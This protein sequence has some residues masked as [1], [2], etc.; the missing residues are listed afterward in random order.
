MRPVD[1]RSLGLE[2]ARSR[3]VALY[4]ETHR[5]TGRL[6]GAL[7]VRYREFA[8]ISSPPA[9]HHSHFTRDPNVRF[10]GIGIYRSDKGWHRSNLGRGAAS[11]WSGPGQVTNK[12]RRVEHALPIVRDEFDRLFLGRVA[13]QH[14]PPP[15]HRLTQHTMPLPHGHPK[16]DIST[17]PGRGHFYFALTL[18]G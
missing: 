12:T 11:R 4:R 3:K 1:S 17:L 8:P 10:E 13:R 15:L 18:S 5:T 16:P 14:C 7:L 6:A 9:P 2:Q